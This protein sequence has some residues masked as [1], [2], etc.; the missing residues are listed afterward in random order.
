MERVNIATAFLKHNNLILILKRSKNV[1]TMK[2]K[3]AG[4]SGY[5]EDELPIDTAIREVEEEVSIKSDKIRLLAK[6]DKLEVIDDENNV[7]WE[8]N[9]FLFYTEDTNIRLEREHDDYKWIKPEDIINYDTVP[10]LREALY[11]CI[12]KMKE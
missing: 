5:I 4:I 8:I 6:G 3:W 9:P 10:K 12:S 11:S 7:I 1:K 2:G